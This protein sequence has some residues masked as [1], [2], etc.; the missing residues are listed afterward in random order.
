LSNSTSLYPTI[1]HSKEKNAQVKKEKV[2]EL[3]ELSIFIQSLPH[4]PAG[5][6]TLSLQLEQHERHKAHISL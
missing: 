5:S 1:L 4:T 2:P 3:R 6:Y